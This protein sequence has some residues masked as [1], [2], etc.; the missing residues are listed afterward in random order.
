MLCNMLIQP[1]FDYAC[2]AWY[3]N[4]TNKTKKKI[5]IIQNKSIQFCLILDKMKYISLVDFR[6]INWLPNKERDHQFINAITLKFVN[7]N[8]PFY[9]NEF[10]EFAP[11]CRIDT[12]NSFAKLQHPFCRTNTA[13]KTL[14]YIG[15]SLWNNLPENIKK[16]II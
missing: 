3:Q 4:L 6:L 9:L 15:H 13:Q 16:R 2:T 1:H 12:R 10:F 8:C 14:S 11:Q 5:Q 7:K